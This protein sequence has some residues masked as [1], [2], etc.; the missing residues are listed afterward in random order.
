MIGGGGACAVCLHRTCGC[1]SFGLAQRRGRRPP[2]RSGVTCP[3]HC[4]AL[5]RPQRATPSLD[6]LALRSAPAGAGAQGRQAP[7]ACAVAPDSQ[8]SPAI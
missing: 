2:P 4:G 7:R 3:V 5:Q 1:L 8:A 6:P